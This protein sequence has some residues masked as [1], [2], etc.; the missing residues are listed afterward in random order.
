MTSLVSSVRQVTG[1][2]EVRAAQAEPSVVTVLC[3]EATSH[4]PAETR[5]DDLSTRLTKSCSRFVELPVGW[6]QWPQLPKVRCDGAR[7]CLLCICEVSSVAAILKPLQ[8]G[9]LE[10]R[11]QSVRIQRNTFH[12]SLSA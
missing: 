4:G 8:S 5:P 10:F 2:S 9:I 11:T 12:T 7:I 6:L 1:G 3:W